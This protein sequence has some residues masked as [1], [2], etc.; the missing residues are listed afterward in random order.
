MG[1]Q[2]KF[3]KTMTLF[4]ISCGVLPALLITLSLSVLIWCSEQYEK[5]KWYK[6][7]ITQEQILNKFNNLVFI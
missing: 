2:T 4:I 7:L 3:Y 5:L 1:Y 6:S